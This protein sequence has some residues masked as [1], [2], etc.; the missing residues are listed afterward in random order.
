MCSIVTTPL[1]V[2]QRS[3]IG[4]QHV[5]HSF[6]HRTARLTASA[7]SRFFARASTSRVLHQWGRLRAASVR[8]W[9]A[10]RV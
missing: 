9:R 3:P 5:G 10:R 6:G 1:S 2:L 8:L 7:L 4:D